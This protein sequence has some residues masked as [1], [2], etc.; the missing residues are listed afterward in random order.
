MTG[1]KSFSLNL[2]ISSGPCISITVDLAFHSPFDAWNLGPVILFV[3]SFDLDVA[4]V[5]NSIHVKFDV[6]E[7]FGAGTRLMVD[8]QERAD[9]LFERD[10]TKL[11]ENDAS[12]RARFEQ[13]LLPNLEP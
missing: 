6:V 11:V 10:D 12:A 4:Q 7:G 8:E 13:G 2:E 5:R 3:Q 9:G 1:V